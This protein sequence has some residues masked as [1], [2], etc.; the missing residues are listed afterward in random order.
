MAE[1]TE[2]T[3]AVTEKPKKH[4]RLIHVNWQ[5]VGTIGIADE[6]G[7]LQVIGQTKEGEQLKNGNVA[8]GIK[9]FRGNEIQEAYV[10]ARK[11]CEQVLARIKAEEE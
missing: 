1:E 4:F 11:L 9:R 5:L 8:V 10:T 7:E 6:D 2:T 3:E